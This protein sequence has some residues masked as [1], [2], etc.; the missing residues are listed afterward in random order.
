[1]VQRVG[2]GSQVFLYEGISSRACRGISDRPGMIDFH[3]TLPSHYFIMAVT[4]EDF[5][6]PFESLNGTAG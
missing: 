6:F 3:Q 4:Q 2:D 1:M 5:H